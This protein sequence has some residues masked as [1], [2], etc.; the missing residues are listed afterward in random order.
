MRDARRVRAFPLS[1]PLSQQ[2]PHQQAESET[3]DDDGT[4]FMKEIAGRETRVGIIRDRG[5]D[6]WPTLPHISPDWDVFHGTLLI[7]VQGMRCET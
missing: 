1:Q 6:V 2:N 4:G 5:L 7:I 3:D